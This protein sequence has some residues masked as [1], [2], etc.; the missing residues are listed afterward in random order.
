M[1]K[2]LNILK[3]RTRSKSVPMARVPRLKE[4]IKSFVHDGLVSSFVTS[5][6]FTKFGDEHQHFRDYSLQTLVQAEAR[7]LLQ[8]MP[9]ISLNAL[10]AAD[11]ADLSTIAVA[12]LHDELKAKSVVPSSPTVETKTVES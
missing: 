5:E 1:F 2:S 4:T 9:V 7:D 6:E 3:P 10:S 11:T 12:R 8:P